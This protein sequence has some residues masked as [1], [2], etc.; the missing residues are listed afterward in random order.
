[1]KKGCEG[2]A[3]PK[4]VLEQR[5]HKKW[6]MERGTVGEPKMLGR[7]RLRGTLQGFT[8]AKIRAIVSLCQVEQGGGGKPR[9]TC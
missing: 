3:T 1:M 2:A 4:K 7:V 6:L 8:S 5:E 9:K